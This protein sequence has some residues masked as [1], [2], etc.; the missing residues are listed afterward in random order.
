MHQTLCIPGR[1]SSPD[2]DC[3]KYLR[4]YISEW[5]VQS[6]DDVSRVY[7]DMNATTTSIIARSRHPS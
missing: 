7:L 2:I 4:T 1:I 3:T 5:R 6:E